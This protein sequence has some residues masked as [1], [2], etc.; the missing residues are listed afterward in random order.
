MALRNKNLVRYDRE[1]YQYVTVYSG[2]WSCQ[3]PMVWQDIGQSVQPNQTVGELDGIDITLTE[4]YLSPMTLRLQFKSEI[5]IPQEFRGA[6]GNRWPELVNFENVTLT[7]RSGKVIPLTD[8]GG[9]AGDQDM[10]WL[11]RL[12]EITALEDLEGGVLTLKIGEESVEIP[13]E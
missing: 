10:N 4:F 8:L 12:E 7:T 9:S 11:F 5:P 2:D 1:K 3:I 6:I 13:L